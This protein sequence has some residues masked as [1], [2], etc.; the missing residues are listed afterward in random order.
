MQLLDDKIYMIADATNEQGSYVVIMTIYKTNVSII[1][2]QWYGSDD[3]GL[4]YEEQLSLER[5]HR[6]MDKSKA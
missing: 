3:I 5:N 6:E 4:H 1:S 2:T